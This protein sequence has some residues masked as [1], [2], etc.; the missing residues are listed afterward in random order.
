M[1]KIMYLLWV[2][3]SAK[4]FI[5]F[6]SFSLHQLP[7]RSLVISSL[8]DSIYLFTE[9]IFTEYLIHARNSWKL[10]G[11][12]HWK[13]LIMGWI[14]MS[15]T[16]IRVR[17]SVGVGKTCCNSSLT[18]VPSP[19]PHVQIRILLINAQDCMIARRWL[20]PGTQVISDPR[21]ML[22]VLP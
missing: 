16:E 8:T 17:A 3:S 22:Y 21:A 12:R 6:I 11:M 7:Q 10:S 13:L 20:W 1:G 9:L 15:F 14:E 5:F 4:N 18:P 2:R 19:Q